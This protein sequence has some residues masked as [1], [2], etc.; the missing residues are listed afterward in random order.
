MEEEY[1]V[2][3]IIA[4]DAISIEGYWGHGNSI[5]FQDCTFKQTFRIANSDIKSGASF[6]NCKFEKGLLIQRCT[7]SELLED[8]IQGKTNSSLCL[9]NCDVSTLHIVGKEYEGTVFPTVLHRGLKIINNT[10]SNNL[11]LEMVTIPIGDLDIIN[12]KINDAINLR[13]CKI[14]NL[15]ISF[16]KSTINAYL[17]CETVDSS[18]YSFID[19]TFHNSVQVWNGEVRDI[20]FND[21][22][23]HDEV[24][25]TIVQHKGLYIHDAIFKK[26]VLF[27]YHDVNIDEILK[28]TIDEVYIIN[29]EFGDN[30][31]LDSN[32][33][34]YTSMRKAT[35]KASKELKGN[36]FINGFILKEQIELTGTNYNANIVLKNIKC[37]KLY[38]N[39]F[40][41]LATFT[42]QNIQALENQD[43][44]LV[45]NNSNLGKT[46]LIR[47]ELNKFRNIEI[48]D[49][50]LQSIEYSNIEWFDSKTIN[51][52]IYP[53]NK[54]F[55]KGK[56]EV[57]RQFKL[58]AD[59]N[60][61]KPMALMFKSFEMNAYN[62][63]L[64]WSKTNRS[65]KLIL[66][67]NSLSNNHGLSWVRGLCFTSIVWIICF[68]I[69]VITRDGLASPWDEDSYF[70]YF[71]VN[72]WREAVNFLWLPDG[73]DSLTGLTKDKG[74]YTSQHNIL[75]I[76]FGTVC[77]LLGKIL[78]AYG[79]FQTIS[80]FRKYVK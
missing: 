38:I 66:F 49:S 19:S 41:N 24:K 12:S 45:I 47:C 77:F 13:F 15:G 6:I 69:F 25:F 70:I 64:D 48:L 26:Q 29:S 4:E 33:S 1:I 63:E 80:A 2:K 51:E 11:S 40:N 55:H 20:T 18:S 23:F 36:I 21:G 35:I 65:D 8:N 54:M 50:I 72:F 30:F 7:S 79:I 39:D 37:T 27:K 76:L 58:C 16:T 61:D 75:N 68:T 67:L 28:G 78:I 3:N 9:D 44:Q 43:P 71:D 52:N 14:N 22:I 10:S 46:S 60:Q 5:I 57:F 56:R 53:Q 62:L 31:L 59:R 73:F 74:I 32:S 34:D 42:L 17:R